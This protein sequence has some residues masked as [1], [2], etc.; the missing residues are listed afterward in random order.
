LARGPL[1]LPGDAAHPA[2]RHFPFPGLVA[3]QVIEKTTILEQRRIMRMGEHPDLSV[4]QDQTTHEIILEITF[5]R[6]AERLLREASPCFPG[7]V[8][9][10]EPAPEFV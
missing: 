4:G 8:I 6:A 7:N 3:D 9:L 2:D 10:L 5:D 1:E